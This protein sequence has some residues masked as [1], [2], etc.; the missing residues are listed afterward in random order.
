[1]A[2]TTDTR[3]K[4]RQIPTVSHILPYDKTLGG[5]AVELYKNLAQAESTSAKHVKFNWVKAALL[6]KTKKRTMASSWF[7]FCDNAT[8]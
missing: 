6:P 1:M 8:L 4:G 7:S 3:R 2:V 5:E